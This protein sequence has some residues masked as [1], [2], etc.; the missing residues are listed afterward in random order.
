MATQSTRYYQKLFTFL[1]KSIVK[2]LKFI[3]IDFEIAVKTE[4]QKHFEGTSV[5]ACHF[6]LRAI[7][8]AKCQKTIYHWNTRKN[9]NLKPL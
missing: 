1:Y 8:M 3:I 4:L 6:L 7:L 9:Q 5:K 2:H